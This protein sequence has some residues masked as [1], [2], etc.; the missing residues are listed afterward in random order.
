LST[1]PRGP[2]RRTKGVLIGIVALLLC[3]VAGLGAYWLTHRRHPHKAVKGSARKEFVTTTTPEQKPRP[4]PLIASLPWP[5]YGYDLARTHY[6]PEFKERPPYRAI[7]RRGTGNY[8][9]FPPVV[10]HG[11]IYVAQLFGRF[12]ALDTRTGKLLWTRKFN[13]CSP[14]SPTYDKGVVYQAYIPLPCSNASRS[15]RSGFIIA[16]DARTGRELWHFGGVSSESSVLLVGH[17]LYFGSW[18]HKVYALNV[19]THRVAWTSTTDAEVNS[20]PAYSNGTIY[21]GTDG[22]SVYALGALR[23]KLRWRAGGGSEYFYATPAVA[24]GRVFIGNTDGTMFAFGARTGHILWA[25][26]AGSYVYSPAAVWNRTVYVGSYDGYFR[27]F[28]AATGNLRWKFSAPSSI[29]GAP[30]VLNGIVYFSTCGLCGH[31][32][33]RGAKL[34]ANMTFG[35][36]AR[37]GREVWSWPDGKYSPVVADLKRVYL[38]GKTRVWA[39]VPKRRSPAS[40]P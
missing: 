14:S 29:H 2:S 33:S 40:R 39:L 24:Y 17:L 1:P 13:R 35:L 31:N 9:E 26:P 19:N 30:T 3:G 27:A 8:I 4:K 36:D 11:R 22:G 21:I 5:T 12:L 34:G 6:A 10:A 7:W 18:D 15:S 20:S 25:Q 38:V 28:D 32:G 37:T 23:G 16:F